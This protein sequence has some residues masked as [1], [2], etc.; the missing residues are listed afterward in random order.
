MNLVPYVVPS[1]LPFTVPVSLLFSVTVGYRRLPPTT[2][3]SRSRRRA[4]RLTVLRPSIVLGL[5]LSTLLV[6]PIVRPDPAP[7]G[8]AKQILFKNMEEMFYRFLKQN[9]EF[10]NNQWPFLITVEDV[11]GKTM[12]GAMF[13]EPCPRSEGPDQVRRDHPGKESV[14]QV[15]HG[16]E[17]RHGLSR[18]CGGQRPE[19]RYFFN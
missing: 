4:S 8:L 5:V 15:R 13:K 17:N 10:N 11:E 7:T 14:D 16:Q 19:Q 18:W 2:R 6:L 3:S 12:I 1:S 9:R